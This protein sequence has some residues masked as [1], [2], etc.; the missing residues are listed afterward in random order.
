MRLEDP[1]DI[2][3]EIGIMFGDGYEIERDLALDGESFGDVVMLYG[4]DAQGAR[5]I[6]A[7]E[8]NASG[9]IRGTV[10]FLKEPDYMDNLQA[11][12]REEAFELVDELNIYL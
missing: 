5:N 10:L 3:R 7:S 1:R 11:F 4:M 2:K 12:E 6:L 9:D 8:L